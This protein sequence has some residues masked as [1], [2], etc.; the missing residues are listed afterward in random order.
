MA[1]F[2]INFNENSFK[3]ELTSELSTDCASVFKYRIYA[4]NAESLVITLAGNY[5]NAVY[6]RDGVELAITS[7]QTV[8][9]GIA[10]LYIQFSIQ[11]SGNPG[12][13][14]VVSLSV[15]NN[16]TVE[17]Y[18]LYSTTATRTNDNAK[19]DSGTLTY[20][21]LTDTPNTKIGN[22]NKYIKVSADGLSHE[23]VDAVPGDATYVHTQGAASAVWTI[24][25][26]LGKYP[27]VRIKDGSGNNVYGDIVD[28]DTSNMTITFNTAFSGVAYLN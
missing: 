15:K 8:V 23:Y 9:Y 1:I 21:E 22:E 4:L 20:D 18:N 13:F 10:S 12:V 3:G 7:P 26:L 27:S 5:E 2:N 25:H 14:P 11:N 6:I 24:P 16:T 17:S 28:T 19:C